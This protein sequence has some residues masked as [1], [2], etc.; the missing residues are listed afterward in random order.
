MGI[1]TSVVDKTQSHTL[2]IHM[3][4]RKNYVCVLHMAS[5]HTNAGSVILQYSGTLQYTV[6]HAAR[7]YSET[8][9]DTE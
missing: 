8:H 5:V 1:R 4:H 7:L 6:A 3:H 9:L 2:N